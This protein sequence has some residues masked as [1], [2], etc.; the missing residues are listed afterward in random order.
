[1][2]ERSEP[3]VR[4]A[5]S[6]DHD[7][8][9]A[10]VLAAF[11]RDPGFRLFFA[12]PATFADDA[13]AF[14]AAV[15]GPRLASGGVWVVD[16][17]EAVAMWER[18]GASGGGVR[19][20]VRPEVHR[21]LQRW[22]TAAHAFIPSGPHWYLGILATHPARAGEGLGRL[23]ATPGLAA[24]R[25]DGL[26]CWLETAS[27]ANVAMYERRGWTVAGATD[28]DGVTCTVLSTG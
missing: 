22:E 4:P 14:V 21:R 17:G 27:A 6:A 15:L 9:L 12:D 2:P 23:V 16:D 28:V 20:A 1:M 8:V 18:P 7:T 24:A 11:D 26:R 25:A 3:V 5:T 13:R 19:D 10:T